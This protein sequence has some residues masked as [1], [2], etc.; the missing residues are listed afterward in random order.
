MLGT[1]DHIE[2]TGGDLD[3]LEAVVSALGDPDESVRWVAAFT[4]ATNDGA[5]VR[6]LLRRLTSTEVVPEMRHTTAYVLRNIPDAA[7]RRQVAPVIEALD[8][9]SYRIATPLA[10]S[11]AL[12]ALEAGAVRAAK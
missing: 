12:R 2:G 4:L 1:A 3:A 8:S 10:A 9:G 11:A 7:V 5:V 6:A